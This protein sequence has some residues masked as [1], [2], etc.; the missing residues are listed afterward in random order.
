MGIPHLALLLLLRVSSHLHPPFLLLSRS[1]TPYAGL[2][3]FFLLSLILMTHALAL[4][5]GMK[6]VV[7]V[8]VKI[9]SSFGGWEAKEGKWMDA[10]KGNSV[11]THELESQRCFDEGISA[12]IRLLVLLPP[13]LHPSISFSLNFSFFKPKR[14]TLVFDRMKT[15]HSTSRSSSQPKHCQLFDQMKTRPS[16]QHPQ[17]FSRGGERKGCGEAYSLSNGWIGIRDALKGGDWRL[18]GVVISVCFSFFK[19][20]R[21]TLVFDTMNSMKTRHSLGLFLISHALSLFDCMIPSISSVPL[22]DRKRKKANG[23][24]RRRALTFGR[25]HGTPRDALTAGFWQLVGIIIGV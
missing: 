17:S 6:L 5:D 8:P 23:R 13:F 11:W 7:V 15:R 22:E 10:E 25:M 12:P 9:F 20:K 4:F 3:P 18:V 2:K 14:R 16:R 24:M 1:R 19:P 21:R